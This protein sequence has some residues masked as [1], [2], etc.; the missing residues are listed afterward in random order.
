[1]GAVRVERRPVKRPQW[2]VEVGDRIEVEV[3]ISRPPRTAPPVKKLRRATLTIL[4]EDQHLAV[5]NKPPG[6]LTVP[7]PHREPQT[8]ISQLTQMLRQRD[9]EAEA[10]CIH[11]LDR[12][13][14]GILVFAKSLEI[15]QRMRDQFAARKPKRRYLAFVVGH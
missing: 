3:D 1:G 10:F 4:F 14:S 5:V 9:P 8:V 15:A 6:L 2:V 13:V 12:G 11:R 7:T